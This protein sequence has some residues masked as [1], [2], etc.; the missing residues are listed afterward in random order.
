METLCDLAAKDLGK[1]IKLKIYPVSSQ[2]ASTR[3]IPVTEGKT[4]VQT[5][6]CHIPELK[7][8]EIRTVKEN[9]LDLHQRSKV[10]G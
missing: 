10:W 2:H 5:S 4:G 3:S 7:L 9:Y 1:Q 6:K 8:I